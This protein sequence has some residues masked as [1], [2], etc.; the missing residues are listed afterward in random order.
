MWEWES[1]GDLRYTKTAL[2]ALKRISELVIN[3]SL[4][5][6]PE[7]LRSG[8]SQLKLDHVLDQE[9]WLSVGKLF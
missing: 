6:S 9:A 5:E 3:N 8:G 1:R 2:R 4:D 7:Y